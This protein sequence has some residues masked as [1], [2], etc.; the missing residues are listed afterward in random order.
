MDIQVRDPLMILRS[1]LDATA[2]RS[3]AG[4]FALAIATAQEAAGFGGARSTLTGNEQFSAVTEAIAL[5]TSLKPQAKVGRRTLIRD[6]PIITPFDF[7]LD[8]DLLD[9]DVI[10]IVD[11]VDLIIV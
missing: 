9:L 2:W 5:R 6:V 8:L 7:A 10:D 3:K 1:V 11:I 4:S